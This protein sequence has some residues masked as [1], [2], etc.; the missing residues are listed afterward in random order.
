MR[1][2]SDGSHAAQDDALEAGTRSRPPLRDADDLAPV[3]Q[4]LARTDPGEADLLTT[5]VCARAC[6]CA[7]FPCR[8]RRATSP[9]ASARHDRRRPSHRSSVRGM[10]TSIHN[11]SAGRTST[12]PPP[13]F[14]RHTSSPCD[15]DLRLGAP[16]H[17]GSLGC[18]EDPDRAVG[19]IGHLD[20]VQLRW[21]A[22]EALDR[23]AAGHVMQTAECG[24]RGRGP[25]ARAPVLL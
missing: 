17:E 22:A 5:T 2:S 12:A 13:L 21:G 25:S 1:A 9:P 16:E 3:D 10:R 23:P 20:G 19:G 24:T 14:R 18:I 15:G 7:P 6:R 8:A 4:D 11:T